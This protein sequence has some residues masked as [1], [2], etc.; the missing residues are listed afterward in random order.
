MVSRRRTGTVVAPGQQLGTSILQ[1]AV[2]DLVATARRSGVPDADLLASCTAPYWTA[3]TRSAPGRPHV[4][5]CE[6]SVNRTPVS[7]TLENWS[8]STVKSEHFSTI[9]E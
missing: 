4:S 6:S 7:T 5:S 3:A 2:A 9:G 1:A 8:V